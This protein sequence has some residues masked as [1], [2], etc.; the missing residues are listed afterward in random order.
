MEDSG[1]KHIEKAI[2]L[3]PFSGKVVAYTALSF[4]GSYKG[5][6]FDQPHCFGYVG[7]DIQPYACGEDGLTL[8][9]LLHKYEIASTKALVDTELKNRNF[10]IRKITPQEAKKIMAVIIEDNAFFEALSKSGAVQPMLFLDTCAMNSMITIKAE[11]DITPFINKIIAYTTTSHYFGKE[12][13]VLFSDPSIKYGY[14]EDKAN[15]DRATQGYYNELLYG[16]FPEF[17]KYCVLH[18]LLNKS[19]DVPN[20]KHIA[21]VYLNDGTLLCRDITCQEASNIIHLIKDGK[22]KFE[23]DYARENLLQ[24]ILM[25]LEQLSLIISKVN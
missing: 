22:A 14:V 20:I 5:H 9:Q 8:H 19:G 7:T 4:F 15:G 16:L 12:N 18:Q 11:E 17:D 24:R 23:R 25:I 6:F 1:M 3:L 2:Q 10:L 21:N 13:G